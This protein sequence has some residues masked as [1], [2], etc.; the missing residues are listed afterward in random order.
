MLGNRHGDQ[1][2]A[3]RGRTRHALTLEPDS[4]AVGEPRWNF[5]VDVLASRQM[6]P[7][8]GPGG[9]FI[10]AD[11]D[12]TGCVGALC[13]AA[14]F[15]PRE[16]RASAAATE[17]LFENVVDPTAAAGAEA[18]AGA[19]TAAAIAALK[20]ARPPGEA[21]EAVLSETLPEPARPA[22]APRKALE[23]RLAFGVD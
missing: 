2:I 18:A 14:E 8:R 17:H 19:A 5:H 1:R 9:G 4:L 13:G 7:P 3:G 16:L 10:E 15:L 12:R 22:S 23:A 11:G 20:A 21:F 6:D